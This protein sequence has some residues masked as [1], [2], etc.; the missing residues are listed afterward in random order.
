MH[1][2]DARYACSIVAGAILGIEVEAADT[3]MTRLLE[4]DNYGDLL[5][6]TDLIFLHLN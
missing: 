4:E 2:L 1:L 5:P 3:A 6:A